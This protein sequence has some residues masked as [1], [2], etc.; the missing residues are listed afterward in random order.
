M[1]ANTITKG[2]S[3]AQSY[4]KVNQAIIDSYDALN[5]ST[6]ADRNSNDALAKAKNVQTQLNTIVAEGD[7]SVEAKQ[8]RV[9]PDGVV[10]QVLKERLDAK[11]LLFST[12]IAK[13]LSVVEADLTVTVGVNGDYPTVNEALKALSKRS[14][15]Y[16][17]KGH[18]VE[19]KLKSG[20]VMREQVLL[21][22]MN[23]GWVTITSESSTV[24]VS[25]ES[26]T[27]SFGS[28]NK[29]PL[30]GGRSNAILP[31]LGTLFVMDETGE[32]LSRDGIYLEDK[33]DILVLAGCGV[34]NAGGYGIRA[35]DG[36]RV[37]A[38]NAKFNKAHER[39]CMI[40]QGSTIDAP[41]IDL[42]EA[43]G[44]N[45]F[46]AYR[47]AIANIEGANISNCAEVAV[48]VSESSVVDMQGSNISGAGRANLE[49]SGQALRVYGASSVYASGVIASNAAGN[50]IE[51]STNA[52]VVAD[53]SDLSGAGGIGVYAYY[54]GS[55]VV[56]SSN[57][58]RAGQESVRA[59]SGA[60]ICADNADMRTS[61]GASACL[62]EFG[63]K[64]YANNANASGNVVGFQC[65]RAGE[66]SGSGLKAD[67]CGIGF[68]VFWEGKV[69]CRSSFARNC[70]DKAA[71]ISTASEF[72][73]TDCI[74]TGAKNVGINAFRG[75]DVYLY[76]SSCRKGSSDSSTDIVCTTGSIIRANES[77]GGTNKT[78]NVFDSE[79]VIF[80]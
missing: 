66:I 24:N 29:Y 27:T 78:P 46:R 22:G 79:G 41:G 9:D 40:S 2:E 55:V 18:K 35:F 14:P 8:A 59:S 69:S 63:G 28:E 75:S 80:K 38:R 50:C 76:G 33:S 45:G 30:L 72:K 61:S 25:R 67:N 10:F 23:L 17:K 3:L 68:Y 26:L 21:N 16:K 53:G 62:A 54:G 71:E 13:A 20:F 60:F 15:E 39:G 11:E 56:S 19:V 49:D 31:V 65:S 4:P 48:R 51:V 12:Q 64:I 58:T 77:T 32:A 43:K 70:T 73:A 42:S 1:P 6:K 44:R 5:K 37:A 36:C 57:I 52:T 47:G 34:Q 7:S 74:L